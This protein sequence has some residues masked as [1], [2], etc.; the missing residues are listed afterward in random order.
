MLILHQFNY[1]L[2]YTRYLLDRSSISGLRITMGRDV[3]V[4][5]IYH[6]YKTN[7][8]DI[9]HQSIGGAIPL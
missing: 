4:S 8:C 1:C 9:V 3:I 2:I 7:F 5:I 6:V